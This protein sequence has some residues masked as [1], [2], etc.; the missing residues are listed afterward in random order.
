[1]PTGYDAPASRSEDLLGRWSFARQ[2]Y[3]IIDQTP[4]SW[5]VRLGIHGKWGDGKTTV[6]R[7]I[8]SLAHDDHH[9]IVPFTPWSAKTRDE[10]WRDFLV[11]FAQA[12]QD[13]AIDLGNSI[14]ARVVTKLL[15]YEDLTKALTTVN[16]IAEATSRGFFHLLLEILKPHGPALSR[17]KHQLGERRICVLVDDLDRAE[18]EILPFLFLALRDIFDLPGFAFVLAFDDEAVAS[19]LEKTRLPDDHGSLFLDKLLDFR[20]ALPKMTREQTQQLLLS[21]TKT[22]LRSFD[23]DSLIA[24]V[25]S[26][27]RNPRR[28]KRFVRHLAVLQPT[29]QRFE[30]DEI[31]H[32]TLYLS[33]LLQLESQTLV[34]SLLT[35]LEESNIELL[36]SKKEEREDRR[37]KIVH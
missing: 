6:L 13:N 9:V 8:R 21:L 3:R 17:I 14:P 23:E 10:L 19:V 33:Q 4:A 5:S 16:R 26:M 22:H 35:E 27:P 28:I 11:A 36:V 37:K 20:L 25:S 18:P 2:A 7:Y 24:T 12:L 1:V 29:L 15:K 30:I 31:D 34:Q 32:Y